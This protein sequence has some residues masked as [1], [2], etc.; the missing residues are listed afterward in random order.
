MDRHR[1]AGGWPINEAHVRLAK[2]PCG[3]RLRRCPSAAAGHPAEEPLGCGG[4][5]WYALVLAL[6]GLPLIPPSARLTSWIRPCIFY[7]LSARLSPE[8]GHL[9]GG[10]SPPSSRC[11]RP[12]WNICPTCTARQIPRFV[13]SAPL[14]G[15]HGAVCLS[16]WTNGAGL[17][18]A[19]AWTVLGRG[20][21]FRQFRFAPRHP[22]DNE[23]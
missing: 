3:E 12:A 2:Q 20:L 16:G 19:V 6:I 13:S 21:G 23:P 11:T 17:N 1:P 15:G 7:R 22:V 8:A 9:P 14:R 18:S 10:G 4:V 5:A